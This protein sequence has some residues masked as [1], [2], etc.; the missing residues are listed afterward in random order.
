MSSQNNMAKESYPYKII[1]F[2]YALS[3]PHKVFKSCTTPM[4]SH[5]I[6]SYFWCSQTLSIFMQYMCVSHGHSTICGIEW[7]LWRRQKGRC[8]LI[9]INVSEQGL[10]CN[11]CTRAIMYESS[12]KETKWVCIQLACSRRP[13]AFGGSSSLEYTSQVL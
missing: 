8:P 11:G 9:D 13:R 10:T 1:Q 12:T 2:G 7:W 4:T 5:A 3:S 6:V